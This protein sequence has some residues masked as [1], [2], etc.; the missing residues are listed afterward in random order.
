MPQINENRAFTPSLL[1]LCRHPRSLGD[2]TEKVTGWCDSPYIM[3]AT[4]AI[5]AWDSDPQLEPVSPVYQRS[6]RNLRQSPSDHATRYL[7]LSGMILRLIGT[8]QQPSCITRTASSHLL[9]LNSQRCQHKRAGPLP[10]V[11]II[12]IVSPYLTLI[13]TST[14]T[15]SS[16]LA[17][18]KY[19]RGTKIWRRLILDHPPAA[20]CATPC[21]VLIV[22][23][24]SSLSE[25]ADD[26][27]M[28]FGVGIGEPFL[29]HCACTS[30]TPLLFAFW[31]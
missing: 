3:T 28:S 24:F 22:G 13:N 8:R 12:T 30:V 25:W 31:M 2:G 9:P 20:S 7:V 19:H 27:K 17:K 4:W 18:Y 26:E 5:I 29:E 10:S 21:T 23:P 16:C 1:A 11:Y 15:T 14:P 6:R